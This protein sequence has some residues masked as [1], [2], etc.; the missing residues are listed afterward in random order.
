MGEGP[1]GLGEY[2]DAAMS[3]CR[4]VD[5]LIHDAQHTAEELPAKAHFGHSAAEY[6]VGLA[7]KAG[8]GRLF[9]YHHDPPRTDDQLDAIVADLGRGSVDVSAAAEGMTVDV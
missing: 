4:G 3:L 8:V 2:H 1:D 6:A 9:L 5:V 7:A